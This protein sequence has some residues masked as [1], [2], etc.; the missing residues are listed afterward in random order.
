MRIGGHLF[1]FFTGK[2]RSDDKSMDIKKEE[3]KEKVVH[4]QRDRTITKKG[5]SGIKK[6]GRKSR[7]VLGAGTSI[8]ADKIS[9]HVEGGEDIKSVVDLER[10][11]AVGTASSI[12]KTK[13]AVSRIRKR[14]GINQKQ[15]SNVTNGKIKKQGK[16]MAKRAAKKSSKKAV[17]KTTKKITKKTTK[18]ATK[19]AARVG[20]KV[21]TTAAGSVA[22]PYGMAIGYAA[23][24]VA[25]E[26]VD[27]KF[28]QA[29]RRI[30]I[31]KYLGDRLNA[32]D[33]QND[34]V[35]KLV[36][37][38]IVHKVV[39]VARKV[40]ALVLPII[41][42]IVLIIVAAGALTGAVVAVAYN[43]PIAFLLPPLEGDETV[44]S[45]TASYMINFK[46]EVNKLAN[47]HKDADQ[48]E[49][50][51]QD[52][53]GLG[54]PDNYMDIMIVYMVKYGYGNTAIEMNEENKK[55]LKAVFDDMC[56][57]NTEI[58]TK[59]KGKGKKKKTTK[60]LKVKVTMKTYS[61]MADEYNF[62]DEQREMLANIMTMVKA[63]QSNPLGGSVSTDSRS[64]LSEK[65]IQKITDKISDP[66]AKNVCTFALS[67]V[68]YPY[69]QP[70]RD[71]GDYFDCSSLAYYSW[72]NG[73]VS[74]IYGDSNVAAA[75]AQYCAKN[76]IV[77]SESEMKPGDLIFYSFQHN[78]RY[79]NISHVAIY[80]G[81][82]KIVEAGSESTGVIYRDYYNSGLVMIGRP[83][84]K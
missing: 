71:S 12:K 66:Q 37:D 84:K 20:V 42:P 22:G 82:G 35:F 9:E 40:V 51:Y 56:K 64:E 23:G 32:P 46:S 55:N 48:G 26:V 16:Q 45:V 72:K 49:V 59:T 11:V 18:Q 15:L 21:G 47:E 1:C 43:S 62:T 53:E 81:D 36:K 2:D 38:L 73:G 8:S 78:D 29:E 7:S 57:Y 54:Q 65:E 27:Q 58:V 50:V 28:Y 3:T 4:R 76:G 14:P 19:T 13:D 31:L 63:T 10:D 79:K 25:G 5:E 83:V 30:R 17:K 34:N 61:E 39:F 77:V 68:G 75:E 80:V 70:K 60:T 67:K 74:M 24:K 69:S 44:R 52:Y 33:K 41:L 6:A